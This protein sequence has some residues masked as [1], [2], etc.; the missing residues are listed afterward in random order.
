MLPINSNEVGLSA[1]SRGNWRS[2]WNADCCTCKRRDK[3]Q[4]VNSGVLAIQMKCM[5]GG[6]F[7]QKSFHR[8]SSRTYSALSLQRCLQHRE[9]TYAS[10][11]LQNCAQKWFVP[12][13]TSQQNTICNILPIKMWVCVQ[14]SW[15]EHCSTLCFFPNCCPLSLTFYI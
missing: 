6:T 15:Q 3:L 8:K 14:V 4:A 5:R 13:K 1:S 11:I 9:K 7:F 2:S 10:V 12:Y